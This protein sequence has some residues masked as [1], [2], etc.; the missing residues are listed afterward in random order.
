MSFP[1]FAKK[2]AAWRAVKGAH[3]HAYCF[4]HFNYTDEIEKALQDF[5]ADYGIYKPEA[6]PTT[7][8][9]HLQGYL[10]WRNKKRGNVILDAFPG[11]EWRVCYGSTA[12]N[13]VYCSK[14]ETAIGPVVEWGVKP[15]DQ[16]SKGIA[17]GN[18]VKEKWRAVMAL[19]KTGDFAA[20]EE[21]YPE[22]IFHYKKKVVDH[23]QDAMNDSVPDEH[24]GDMPGVWI[25][26]GAGCGKSNTARRMA[27]EVYGCSKPYIKPC[28]NIWWTNYRF[29][30]TVILDDLDPTCAT[31]THEFKTWIDRYATLVRIHHGLLNINP[32]N[33]IITSQ[34]E[35]AECFDDPKVVEAMTRRFPTVIRMTDEDGDRIRHEKRKLEA[36][37]VF[38]D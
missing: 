11:G 28:N 33:F 35:I 16:T 5:G 34:Y 25:V 37:D 15:M 8:K 32:K 26:G 17:G 18:A 27:R 30:D 9:P 4:T 19:A 7:G 36:V 21:E 23:Y 22:I 38:G 6:C 31:L 13:F 20:I 24:D 12:K 14:K 2:D 1:N 29:Q 10:Y 3:V